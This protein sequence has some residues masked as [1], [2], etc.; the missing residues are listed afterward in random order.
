[1]FGDL[2]TILMKE[3]FVKNVLP[4]LAS[5]DLANEIVVKFGGEACYDDVNVT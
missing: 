3:H 5:Y 2:K 1:M 4:K